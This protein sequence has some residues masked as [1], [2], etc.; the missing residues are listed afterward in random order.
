[1]LFVTRVLAGVVLLGAACV[2]AQEA[3]D[4]AARDALLSPDLKGTQVSRMIKEVWTAKDGQ[5]RLT[6]YTIGDYELRIANF[7]DGSAVVGVLKAGKPVYASQSVGSPPE[8]LFEPTLGLDV[9]KDGSTDAIVGWYSGGMHCCYV[10]QVLSFAPEF[11]AGATLEGGES[12]L[13][14]VSGTSPNAVFRASDGVLGYW[15]SD[16]ARSIFSD[17]YVQVDRDTVSLVEAWMKYP[18][19]EDEWTKMKAESAATFAS[20]DDWIKDP[21]NGEPPFAP[22]A[23][24]QHMVKL[25]YTGNGAQA[26][27]L[28]K[29]TWKGD[30]AKPGVIAADLLAQLS[31]SRYWDGIK[32]LNGWTGEPAAIAQAGLKE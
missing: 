5:G 1:M 32:S 22:R 27:L 13:E 17:V 8:L 18:P 29:E 31:K 16:F 9:D 3:I 12:P 24:M 25:I 20:K 26:F 30:A 4:A 2:S 10:Y 6:A 15:H 11:R 19:S 7:A 28:L 21:V 14:L 23:L